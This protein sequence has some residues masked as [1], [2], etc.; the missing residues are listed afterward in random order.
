MACDYY[1]RNKSVMPTAEVISKN[2]DNSGATSDIST[3]II[4]V[5]G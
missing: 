1:L 2:I 4:P 5:P 3:C